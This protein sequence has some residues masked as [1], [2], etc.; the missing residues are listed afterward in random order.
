MIEDTELLR[1]YL[2]EQ[3]EPAFAELVARHVNLVY[4]VAL[5]RVGGDTHRAEDVTQQVFTALAQKA[6]TLRSHPVLSAWLYTTTR[7]VAAQVV[8]SAVRR[9]AREQEALKMNAEPSAD[10]ERLRPVLDDVLDELRDDDRRAVLLRFFE[11]KSFADVGARLR[12]TD[13]AA[14]MRVDRALE[15]MHAALGRRGVTSTTAAL[16]LALA[17]QAAVTA[18]ASLAPAVTGAALAGAGLMT[19]TATATFMSMTKLQVGVAAAIAAAGTTGYVVQAQNEASLRAERAALGQQASEVVVLRQQTEQLSRNAAEAGEL[20]NDDL[21]LTRLR[22][23]AAALQ[24]RQQ[25]AA[26]AAAAVAAN[27]GLVYNISQLDQIPQA[28][29]RVPPTYPRE[30]REAGIGGEVLV[31]FIVD[32][33]GVVQKAFAAKSS[34]PEFEAAA[35]EAVSKWTFSPGRKSQVV[36]NARMQIPI[37]FTLEA[38]KDGE[39]KAV[40]P[41]NWF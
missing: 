15:K 17:G 19:A 32:D 37:V 20:R 18:P 1:R 41:P 35:V 29:S 34:R 13:N 24:V 14:R 40:N 38:P 5:R 7:N 22:D 39:K 11:G 4:G 2:D 3:S 23:E 6:R 31:D 12:L 33:K 9:Q 27:P 10:W 25:A 26:K 28:Q 8:R 16:G 30:M 36:V 21:E